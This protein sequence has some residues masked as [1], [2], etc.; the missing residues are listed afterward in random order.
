MDIVARA[1]G[2]LFKPKEEWAKIKGEP[3]PIQQLFTSYA[4]ILAAIPVVA[5]F[6][7]W[8]LVGFRIPYVGGSWMG[9]AILY[10]I[11]SYVF[12]LVVVYAFGIIINALAPNFSSTQNLPNAMKLAV[13]S[14]TPAWL[15]GIFH[16]IPSLGFLAILGSLYGIYVLYLG[17]A[18]PLMGTPKEKVVGY[19]VISVVVMIVLSVV[20]G[21]I[22]GAMFAMRGL[23]SFF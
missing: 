8:A 22:L 18:T 23:V 15:A 5:Q 20:V 9:R 17:F 13:Y 2:I 4:V 3:T 6:L 21:L 1:Q 14:M 11:F 10:S 7:G 19:M 16:I 12:S